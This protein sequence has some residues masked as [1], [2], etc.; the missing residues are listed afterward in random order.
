MIPRLAFV[1]LRTAPCLTAC[2]N[3][4]TLPRNQKIIDRRPTMQL[5]IEINVT[6]SPLGAVHTVS[7][8]LTSLSFI[9]SRVPD[10]T[11]APRSMT[12]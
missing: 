6:V 10:S 4:L 5:R 1:A 7:L 9:A 8:R 3:W 11:T 2:S 12:A